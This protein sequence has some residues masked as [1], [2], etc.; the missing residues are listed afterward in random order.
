LAALDDKKLL[1]TSIGDDSS[2]DLSFS[3]FFLFFLF[4]SIPYRYFC[5]SSFTSASSFFA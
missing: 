2:I 1:L 5:K 4:S 3:L